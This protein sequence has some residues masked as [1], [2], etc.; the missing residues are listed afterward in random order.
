MLQ[1]SDAW[2]G[3]GCL[4]TGHDV[5][6]EEMENNL[7]YARA[8]KASLFLAAFALPATAIAQIKFAA[9]GDIGYTANSAAVAK[10]TRD[11]N[12]QF[13]LMLGDLCYGSQPLAAQIDVNYRAERASG[14]LWPVL[15]NHEF[16]DRCGG[17]N[18][19]S[20]YRTYFSL[21]NNERYYDF[22][23]GPVH[24]FA[25]N[26]HKDPDGVSA[27]SKQAIWLKGKLAASTSPWQIVFFHH[28]PFSSGKH[29]STE[30]MIWPFEAWGADAVL[31]GHD[32]GYE[33]VMGDVDKDGVEIPYFVSGLGG[34]SLRPFKKITPGSV[35]RYNS[36]FGALFVAATSTSMTFE[37][38]TTNG[39][40]IDKYLKTQSFKEERSTSK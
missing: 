18:A 15:G 16:K 14:K 25:L 8:W 6:D 27:D 26:S 28:P 9:F 5:Y 23:R 29:G 24:F 35:K 13:I 12:A 19:A 1:K 3:N 40:L 32:H 22:K 17:G 4:S 20:G 33:R 7:F 38:R 31:S 2:R 37:F 34:R 10:L 21:P 11:Y 30:R 39:T 36:T